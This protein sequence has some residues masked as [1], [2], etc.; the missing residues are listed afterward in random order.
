MAAYRDRMRGLAAASSLGVCVAIGALWA[1]PL[2]LAAQDR[3]LDGRWTGAVT[4]LGTELG[5]SVEFS[6]EGGALSATMDIPTQGAQDLPLTD[7]WENAATVHFELQAG[8]GLAV[9][10]GDRDGDEIAG[11]FT[12]GGASGTFQ[13]TRDGSDAAAERE[14]EEPVPYRQ[15]ELTVEHGEIRLAGTLTLP[16]D[17]GPFPAV[18][19][20]TGSGPQ[21]RDE[22]IFG[23]R[24]FRVIADHLTRQGIAVFRYDDRGVGGSNGNVAL[25]TTSDFADDAIASIARLA[26]HPE[27]DGDRIGIVGHSEGGVVAPLAAERSESVAFVILLAGTSVP[28]SEIIF[29]QGAAIARAEEQSEEQIEDGMALQRQIFTAMAAGEDME[30][31]RDD[32][33]AVVREQ[34]AN[35]PA[36]NLE[37]VVADP[38]EFVKSQVNTQMTQIKTPWFQYFITYDPAD[39]L[40]Q[41]TVPALALFGELDLQVLPAQNR[42]PMAEA[43]G[44][45]PD[46]T[47]HTFPRANHL[48]QEAVTG[49]PTEYATL[50]RGFV[51]GFLEMISDWILERM[52]ADTP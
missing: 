42:G 30:Q 36:E 21:N 38:E 7:V 10:E 49:S 32:I 48:F 47:F 18:V 24:I 31:F 22:E 11:T 50:E 28:G 27:I 13:V 35:A 29:E 23:F 16:E 51:P 3:G 33:E 46:V 14:S 37:G 2:P 1:V 6:H 19:M 26:E 52:G 8:P 9:W 44:G 17:G 15:E 43:L 39:A 4:I 20:V 45:N 12:Q 34:M 5:F 25:S 41:T 40:R